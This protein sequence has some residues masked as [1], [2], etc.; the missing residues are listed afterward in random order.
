MPSRAFAIIAAVVLLATGAPVRADV[1]DH[2]LNPVLDKMLEGKSVKEVKQLTP[3]LILEHDRVLPGVPSAFLLVRT[4]GNRLAKLLVQAAKQRIDSDKAVPILL[5]ERFVTFKDGE[6][7]TRH[8]EGKNLSLFAGFRF[9]LDLGQVVP[10]A[11]GGDIRFVV[12]GDKVYAEPV[13]KAKM[14]LVTKHD[15]GVIPKKPGRFV[16]GPKFDPKYF[17]GTFKLHDD[18]RRSGK[19][20]LKVDKDGGVTGSYYSDKDGQKYDVEGKIGSPQHAVEFRVRFPR[21]EQVFKGMLFTG[22]GK[23]IAGTSRLAEREAA[24]YAV[25]AE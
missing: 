14:Y 9:S 11:V 10:E 19:L 3:N 18:G 15:P 6:E 24:F 16:M 12:E 5:V 25:R 20:I 17:A 7:Q 8:A 22:N 21:S 13:G 4:N 23:A 2:Y 1:F